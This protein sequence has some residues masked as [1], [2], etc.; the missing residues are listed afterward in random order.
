MRRSQRTLFSPSM[1]LHS[2]SLPAHA[3]AQTEPFCARPVK[4]S[5]SAMEHRRSH[6]SQRCLIAS[7]PRHLTHDGFHPQYASQH[8][9]HGSSRPLD[10]IPVPS[11]HRLP[12]RAMPCDGKQGHRA[13]VDRWFSILWEVVR[14]HDETV[15][16][17]AG[18]SALSRR[19]GASHF[20][21][22]RVPR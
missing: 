6:P 13:R 8:S 20:R 17:L 9:G 14:D 18:G 16:S 5:V 2:R 15:S 11:I 7:L 10:R 21:N 1:P 22:I 4:T 3:Q 19:A 12:M